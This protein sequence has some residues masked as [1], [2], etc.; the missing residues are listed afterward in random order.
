LS[1]T[2]GY[3]L[4][5]RAI[6]APEDYV[7]FVVVGGAMIAF[8]MNVMWSMSAQLVLGERER[9]P[10]ALHHGAQLAHGHH[11][12]HGAR[13]PA[14]H[15]RA[16]HRVLLLGTFIFQVHYA[17]SSLP[18]L[19]LIFGLTMVALYGLGML[20]ASL[21]LLMGRDA[22]QIVNLFQEPVYFRGRLLLPGAQLRLRHR[23]WPPRSS[24]S[25]SGLDAM[26][27]LV[28]ASGPDPRLP[29]GPDRSRHP[30]R[31][32]PHPH[33][34]RQ[35]LARQMERLAVMEGTLGDRRTIML[36]TLRRLIHTGHLLA[37]RSSPIGP[38]QCCFDLFGG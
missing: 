18:L 38:T 6:G 1:A 25:P 32:R 33:R 20:F 23:L 26:R 27:Q 28:F 37:G 17:V 36:A 35:I 21:F 13:R 10:A 29:I 8:W 9:Q 30:G 5:Y 2:A 12:R 14:V 34:R 16:R 4:V 7:G 31:S 15:Y 19:L 22:W 24:R 3:V 11:A